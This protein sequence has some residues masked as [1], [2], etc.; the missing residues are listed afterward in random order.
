MYRDEENVSPI[1]TEELWDNANR[2]LM[3]RSEKRVPRI[4]AAIKTS[5][6]TAGKSSAAFIRRPTIE[7]FTATKVEIKRCGSV[8][9]M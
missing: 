5:T 8:R 6:H 7:A 2:L 4:K 1:V 9:N 3:R